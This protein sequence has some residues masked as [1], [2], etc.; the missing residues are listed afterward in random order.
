MFVDL[1]HGFWLQEL[2]R[3]HCGQEARSLQQC[4]SFSFFNQRV[5]ALALPLQTSL[6]PR[7]DKSFDEEQKENKDR[8]KR[9]DRQTGERDRKRHQKHSL[10][11]EDQKDYGIEIILCVE[12]NL[13]VADRFDAAF[14]GRSLVRAGFWRL[15]K[16]PPQPGQRQWN[17]WKYQR[18][19]NEN[20]NEQIWIRPHRVRLNSLGNCR[21][22]VLVRAVNRTV[23]KFRSF[24]NPERTD[25]EFYKK[26]LDN[27]RLQVLVDRSSFQLLS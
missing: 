12:L 11:V 20:D 19:A 1:A 9:S 7:P 15:E 17:Q 8:D 10:N 26:L 23:T 27:E 18:H 4:N 22:Q 24:A 21:C 13:R 16:S 14:V 5:S 3:W 2:Q 25:R 6:A